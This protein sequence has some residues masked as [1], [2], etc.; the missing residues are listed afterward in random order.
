M[1][2]EFIDMATKLNEWASGKTTETSI[3]TWARE[4]LN[5]ILNIKG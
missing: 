2:K 3:Q 1:Y 4:Y 5:S